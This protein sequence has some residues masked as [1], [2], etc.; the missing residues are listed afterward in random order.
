MSDPSTSLALLAHAAEIRAFAADLDGAGPLLPKHIQSPAQAMAIVYAGA[1]IGMSPMQAIRSLYLVE[2]R[3][4]IDASAQLALAIRAGVSVDWERSDEEEAVLVLRR[5]GGSYRSRYTMEHARR[6][7]LAGRGTW[8]KHPDAMLRARAITAGIRA[9]CPDVLGGAAY[10][11]GE[12]DEVPERVD[13][14]PAPV[15]IEAEVVRK[16]AP[17]AAPEHDPSWPGAARAFMARLGELGVSYE[18]WCA[19]SAAH[20]LHRPSQLPAEERAAILA[21]L[22]ADPPDAGAG[23]LR[24]DV[25]DWAAEHPDLVEAE[26]AAAKARSAGR[27]VGA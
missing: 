13:V 4:V 11:R 1:E 9:F 12:I 2:G 14:T 3:V 25:L 17:K 10:D 7:G 21:D 20:N 19:W 15:V 6:A 16:P 8:Q 5:A 27:K 24:T 22:A 26:R 23:C 18:V